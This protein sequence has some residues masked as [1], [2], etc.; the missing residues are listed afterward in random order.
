MAPAVNR[1]KIILKNWD[2]RQKQL[3]SSFGE[4]GGIFQSIRSEKYIYMRSGL[5]RLLIAPSIDEKIYAGIIMAMLKNMRK[6]FFPH[7]FIRK[8]A[9]WKERFLTIPRLTRYFE[10][11]MNENFNK[12]DDRIRAMGITGL[13]PYL[14][15]QL[16]FEREKIALPISSRFE[17]DSALEIVLHIEKSRYGGYRLDNLHATLHHPA[18]GECQCMIDGRHG[19]NINQVIY[20]LKGG[21]VSVTVDHSKA[22]KWLQIDFESMDATGKFPLRELFVEEG[23]R[24]PDLLKKV[25]EE[26]KYPAIDRSEV[27]EMINNGAQVPFKLESTGM[28]YLEANPKQKELVFRDEKQRLIPMEVLKKKI[29]AHKA[30][31]NE[32]YPAIIKLKTKK[33]L[34]QSNAP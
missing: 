19:L 6:E 23:F 14:K 13:S 4:D 2:E 31:V 10:R 16:D 27:L 26:L 21:A 9:E 30:A 29:T 8:I 15:D 7:L 18:E 28:F 22:E 11:E 24:A 12:L 5:A 1:G 25:A 32:Q 33:S 20:L 34:D 3:E 17:Q